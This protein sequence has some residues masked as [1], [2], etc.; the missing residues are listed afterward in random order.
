M[1]A[2]PNRI[3]IGN[4]EKL[5]YGIW[6]E[7]PTANPKRQMIFLNE[8][9]SPGNN[10]TVYDV[11]ASIEVEITFQKELIFSLIKQSGT[12]STVFF[13]ESHILSGYTP[14]KDWGLECYAIFYGSSSDHPET[15]E[16]DFYVNVGDLTTGWYLNYT[17]YD[18]SWL[19]SPHKIKCVINAGLLKEFWIDDNK[20]NKNITLGNSW[21]NVCYT[22]QG[23]S[24][25]LFDC[26]KWYNSDGGYL[27][28][29]GDRQCLYSLNEAHITF[30]RLNNR[31]IVYNLYP[32]VSS[33]G[34]YGLVNKNEN[35]SMLNY[36]YGVRPGEF[37]G[38]YNLEISNKYE[39]TNDDITS[40]TAENQT[41]LIGDELAIDVVELT[42]Q[43]AG[44]KIKDGVLL[45]PSDSEN[46]ST[47]RVSNIPKSWRMY[48][49]ERIYYMHW[50]NHEVPIEVYNSVIIQNGSAV[51][52]GYVGTKRIEYNSDLSV[53]YNL[54]TKIGNVIYKFGSGENDF[55]KD[56]Y[57][58]SYQPVYSAG[59]EITL[60][61]SGYYKLATSNEITVADN[62]VYLLNTPDNPIKI[63][64]LGDSSS[65]DMFTRKYMDPAENIRYVQIIRGD[66]YG[67]IIYNDY[68]AAGEEDPQY[69]VGGI[70]FIQWQSPRIVSSATQLSEIGTIDAFMYPVLV[71]TVKTLIYSEGMQSSDRNVLQCNEKENVAMIPY[72]TKVK[73]Y[74]QDN[75]NGVYYTNKILRTGP[76]EYE[77]KL[78]SIVGILDKQYHYG[79]M[80]NGTPFGTIVDEILSNV[81][82]ITTWSVDE[83]VA[84]LPIFGWLPYD[85]CRNN[86]H[87]ILTAT[88][89]TIIKS[90]DG[91]LI[92]TKIVNMKP[93][94]IPSDEIYY[95]G[96]VDYGNEA[97]DVS[98]TEHYYAI[99]GDEDYETLFDNTESLAVNNRIVTFSNA[100][101]V[102]NSLRTSEGLVVT[103]ANCNYAV[104]SGQGV[105][106][107][108][109]YTHLENEIT[110]TNP[111]Y[112]ETNSV[113]M[114]NITVITAQNSDS[115]LNRLY[116]YFTKYRTV[117]VGL[118]LNKEKCGLLYKF[119]DPFG[120][121]T[122]GYLKSMSVTTGSFVKADCE[123]ISNYVPDVDS[124][125]KNHIILTGSGTWTVP[126][127]VSEFRAVLIGGGDGGD[128][129]L[130]GK[131]GTL[132]DS[133]GSGGEGGEG[134]ESGLGGRI[135]TENFQVGENREYV[136]I[137]GQGGE[138]GSSTSSTEDH[139][140]GS[141]G[142]DTVFGGYSTSGYPT[143]AY[144]FV[145]VFT[146]KAYGKAGLND[147]VSGGRGG[148]G[149]QG[150]EE[151]RA[152]ESVYYNGIT[153]QCGLMGQTVIGG[154]SHQ[155]NVG[156]YCGG[157]GAGGAAVGA[158]NST[159]L[160]GGDGVVHSE[161]YYFEP[162]F[163]KYENS[164][165]V[166]P[167]FGANGA[168]AANGLD[169]DAYGCGGHGGHG[170]GGAGGNGKGQ[171][172]MNGQDQGTEYF[173]EESDPVLAVSVQYFM[174]RVDDRTAQGGLG[175]AGGR[176]GDGC[177]IIYY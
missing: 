52:D 105:L 60:Y 133:G 121:S 113:S 159:I 33:D 153:Y 40:L 170:G 42:V 124:G 132:R 4:E 31:V 77:L 166:D 96:S 137:C 89:A 18:E 7:V 119:R 76:C 47:A 136:Y 10:C 45:I 107:G 69:F 129:G 62:N 160:D 29:H 93:E 5:V 177:V 86:L 172:T 146:G 67:E 8:S 142:T 38:A 32:Y 130:A 139:V 81:K 65:V 72:A 140:P 84:Q 68:S 74:N 147:S 23:V 71:D 66:I 157:G 168:D 143:S 102:V 164:A 2:L 44:E 64:N 61:P 26:S 22:Q 148:D 152:A 126:Y 36:F 167:G 156:W 14:P 92:F 78:Q 25:G 145:D 3:V 34:I 165:S 162:S 48:E 24:F 6:P 175:G 110:K 20:A 12:C 11:A 154:L 111:N 112:I 16:I 21:S 91:S 30:N 70:D 73:W 99:Y 58:N 106:E 169:G 108:Y 51:L 94:V 87:Q 161:D 134:G 100:P 54:Y 56:L 149:E 83:D 135:R 75:L 120:D 158:T 13:G 50:W 57:G 79:G 90:A 118:K 109:A 173:S 55:V 127:G 122:K 114:D 151:V 141:P 27:G 39:F 46:A 104:V 15:G 19:D 1:G 171:A 98:V 115:I 144:G 35:G 9:L 123:F 131:P 103:E 125:Y 17:N 82:S 53:L 80:Y 37:I 128:S 88:N 59:S 97:S 176:G 63:Y 28:G 174:H 116:N 163:G 101:I 43:N 41:D 85:T 117:K 49:Y 138:G 150:Q 95:G 155:P